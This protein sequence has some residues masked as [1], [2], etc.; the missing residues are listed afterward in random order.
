MLSYWEKTTVARTSDFL[1]IGAGLTG[2]CTAHRLHE[3]NPSARIRIVERGPFPFGASTR[4]AGFA[5][6]GSPSELISDIAEFGPDETF[7][8]V[9]DRYE[10]LQFYLS[11]FD[12]KS[13]DYKAFGGYEV[14]KKEDDQTV[15]QLS[16]QLPYLNAQLTEYIGQPAFSED[17]EISRF[18]MS[19]HPT[20]FY[21]QLEG[22]LHPGKLCAVI[23]R[24]LREK[25]VDFKY[26]VDIQSVDLE[27]GVCSDR[28]GIEW[29]AGKV[30]I[31]TN[32]L[33]KSLISREDVQPARGQILLTAP[34]SGLKVRGTF[35]FDEGYWYFRNVGN[36]LL[37]G[38]GRNIDPMKERTD[39]REP[40]ETI[41]R[42]LLN[43]AHS[44]ILPGK[45]FAV[46]STWAGTMAFGEQN[47]KAPLIRALSN[48]V[49]LAVRLGGMGVA[50]APTVAKKTV[51]LLN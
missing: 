26:G 14:F 8:R 30:I 19:T 12:S 33:T 46:Q 13:F 17:K 41:Q 5:C 11:N 32:G 28:N 21:N 49:I 7:S 29:K 6:F 16:K 3:R 27:S 18:G 38:G 44:I 36:Q 24:S 51:E 45:A 31:C 48:R 43:M 37:L 22:Q 50:L 25:G 10:G 2:L 4:N 39:V 9:K 1:I 34:I 23:E 35:H 20:G 15:V 40:S 42:A 47:E